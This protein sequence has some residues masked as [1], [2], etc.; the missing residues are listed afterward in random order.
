MRTRVI[1]SASSMSAPFLDRYGI[2]ETRISL[3]WYSYYI[4]CSFHGCP[5]IFYDKATSRWHWRGGDECWINDGIA[6]LHVGSSYPFV[7]ISQHDNSPKDMR[8]ESSH[9]QNH[10]IM[11]SHLHFLAVWMLAVRFPFC[12][13]NILI[14]APAT[15]ASLSSRTR[16]SINFLAFFVGHAQLERERKLRSRN[17]SCSSRVFR[18]RCYLPSLSFFRPDK[19]MRIERLL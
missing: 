4:T 18:R 17:S 16:Q 14:S 15:L 8:L 12:Y 7:T 19:H 3:A 10:F 9:L 1:P 13:E 2:S 6:P 11:E 5:I